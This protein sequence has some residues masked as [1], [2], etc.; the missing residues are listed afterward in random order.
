MTFSSNSFSAL[1][2]LVLALLPLVV[3]AGS[4]S[5]SF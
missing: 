2:S 3:I 5:T 1:A 4:I